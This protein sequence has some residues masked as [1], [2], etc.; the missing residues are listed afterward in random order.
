MPLLRRVKLY[1]NSFLLSFFLILTHHRWYIRRVVLL[2]SFVLL[3]LLQKL[4]LNICSWQLIRDVL[5]Y[6]EPIWK[7]HHHCTSTIAD[8]SKQEILWQT[9]VIVYYSRRQIL[10]NKLSEILWH[11][12]SFWPWLVVQNV[13]LIKNILIK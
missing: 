1:C 5:L 4:R 8:I 7:P 3:V 11:L 13:G 12:I 10:L 2:I 6:C 9:S